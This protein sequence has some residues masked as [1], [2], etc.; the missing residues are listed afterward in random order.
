ML[1]KTILS[2][3]LILL[4]GFSPV[5]ASEQVLSQSPLVIAKE[6]GNQIELVK[7]YLAPRAKNNIVKIW[8]FF[9]DKAVFNNDQFDRAADKVQLTAAA[10]Q[11]RAISGIDYITFADL[12]VNQAYIDQIVSMGAKLRRVS[13]WLNGA[14]F[15]CSPDL[16]DE[17][18]NLPFAAKIRPVASFYPE[19]EQPS[20]AADK[21]YLS[22]DDANLLNY[23]SSFAQLDQVNIP[24]V[25]DQGYNGAG[26]IVAM[27][28]TGYFKDHETFSTAFANGRVLAEWDFIFNDGNTQNEGVDASDQ[29]RH[30]TLTWSTLGGNS[31]G[32]LYGPAYGASFILAKTEDVRSE[33]VVEEDNWAAAVEWA[34]S[35]GARV[36]SSSLS[37]SD[38]Y[39]Y[40]NYDGETAI[41]TIAANLATAMGIIVCNSSGN[42]GPG[43]G[44]IAAPVDAFEILAVGAATSSGSIAS[45]SSR[46]PT[47]DGRIKPE[48]TAQGVSTFCAG[49]TSTTNYTTASGTSL[50]CPIIGGCAAVLLSARPSFT[51]QLV[52]QAMMETAS[53]AHNPDNIFGWGIVDMDAAIRWGAKMS[54]D[55]QVGWVPFDVTFS[56]DSPVPVDSRVWNLGEGAPETIQN[57]VHTYSQPGSYNVSLTINSDGWELTDSRTDHIIALADTIIFRSDTVYAGDQAIIDIYVVNSQSLSQLTIPFDYSIGMNL[58][59][60][61]VS[62]FG[63]RAEGLPFSPLSQSGSVR[64]YK[65]ADGGSPLLPG[66]GP[67]IRIYVKSDIYAFGGGTTSFDT[68]TINNNSLDFIATT[69]NYVPFVSGGQVVLFDVIRGDAN[70]D[71]HLNVG[72]PVFMI[73]HVFRSGPAPITI[74]SG[75]A[76]LDFQLNTGDA[77][78]V[79][80]FIFKNGPPPNDS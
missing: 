33:M 13:R 41:T 78:Y 12:S 28:D 76:N 56:D 58:I 73:N 21:S 74:E 70:N 29:H 52:R 11:R 4:V 19:K 40:S 54:S 42:A 59:V 10:R 34:D 23:G 68:T 55:V 64:A 18:N 57:P 5:L 51:P 38:W 67:V 48:V 65:L 6:T 24:T 61:S 63:T 15:E 32:T 49:P 62:T 66:S 31:S 80:N 2:F 7:T 14:S 44:T 8:V 79:V 46:G 50:S 22:P 77:V 1:V 26:I 9:T 53:Q 37:Y 35:I 60:D 17:L 69:I 27:F 30:G 16:I 3:C 71:G 47:A 39:V 72:D 43:A 45:F 75:D 20:S 25:H 36:I